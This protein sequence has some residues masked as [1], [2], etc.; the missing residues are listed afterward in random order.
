MWC[1][2]HSFKLAK[3]SIELCSIHSILVSEFLNALL[4]R[5]YLYL[6]PFVKKKKKKQKTLSEIYWQ[7]KELH[8]ISCIFLVPY[9][10]FSFLVLPSLITSFPDC[11]QFSKLY[12]IQ[13]KREVKSFPYN[14]HI[15]PNPLKCLAEQKSPST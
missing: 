7:N 2:L 5:Y 11:P 13:A 6:S 14:K 1:H 3:L 9:F 12:S 15:Y 8:C 4:K 10:L